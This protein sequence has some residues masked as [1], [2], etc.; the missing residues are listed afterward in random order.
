MQFELTPQVIVAAVGVGIAVQTAIVTVAVLIRGTAKDLARESAAREESEKT[1][2]A[3]FNAL[4]RQVHA[5]DVALHGLTLRA[6]VAERGLSSA[7]SSL[8]QHALAIA[9]FAARPDDRRRRG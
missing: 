3:R 7:T 4:E 8:A 6:D 5:H 9:A 2:E 1:T